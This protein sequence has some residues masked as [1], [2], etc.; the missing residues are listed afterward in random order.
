[1]QIAVSHNALDIKGARVVANAINGRKRL[2][3]LY[4]D[5]VCFKAEGAIIVL[6]ALKLTN[7]QLV[8]LSLSLNVAKGACLGLPG[9]A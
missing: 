3:S 1:M 6:D 2:R 5:N 8:N 4:L 7:P 9:T